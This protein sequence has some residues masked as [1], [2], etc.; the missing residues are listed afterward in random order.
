VSR[1]GVG[2]VKS[3]GS[4]VVDIPWKGWRETCNP[5]VLESSLSQG[6]N[7]IRSVKILN[8]YYLVFNLAATQVNILYNYYNNNKDNGYSTW[9]R[10]GLLEVIKFYLLINIY[11]NYFVARAQGR[12]HS[13]RP[14]GPEKKRQNKC[15]LY[16]IVQ[17]PVLERQTNGQRP[18]GDP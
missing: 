13:P 16:R 11:C 18:R 8:I 9:T 7:V 12:S 5:K 6:R 3:Q 14:K 1:N 4:N 2:N 10:G 15:R 17:E